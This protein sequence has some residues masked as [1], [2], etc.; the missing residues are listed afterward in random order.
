VFREQLVG[1]GGGKGKSKGSKDIDLS[2]KRFDDVCELL[3]FMD[4]RVET[5]LTG[6]LN[7]VQNTLSRHVSI[8]YSNIYN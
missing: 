7:N 3:A 2:E 4:P 8:I 6:T 5:D 1:D